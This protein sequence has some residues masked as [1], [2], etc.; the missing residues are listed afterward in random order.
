M[1]EWKEGQDDEQRKKKL[2][3]KEPFEPDYISCSK[4]QTCLYV[5]EGATIIRMVFEANK[6]I[7][8]S[9][10]ACYADAKMNDTSTLW[11]TWP[12]TKERDLLL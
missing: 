2:R 12:I 9:L 3:Y 1:V 7:R 5:R 10:S 11:L 4:N 6:L 8:F